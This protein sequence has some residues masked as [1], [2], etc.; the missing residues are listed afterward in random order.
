MYNF[1][2][3]LKYRNNGETDDLFR[4]EFLE[5]LGLPAFEYNIV[6]NKMDIL[7]NKYQK[8]F[9]SCIKIIKDNNQFPFALTDI[10]AFQ[11]LFS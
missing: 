8:F 9:T 1:S 4:K 2:L 7:Y 10:M 11:I 6:R 3:K 5:V